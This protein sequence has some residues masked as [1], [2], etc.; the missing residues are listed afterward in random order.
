MDPTYK[1]IA[2]LFAVAQPEDVEIEETDTPREGRTAEE[3]DA[4][5]RQFL[6]DGNLEAALKHFRRAVEQR[7]PNDPTS[8]VNLAG[9]L[10]YGDQ[11]PQ[12]LRQYE[13]ALRLKADNVEPVVGVADL[14][15]RYGRFRDAIEKLQ[16]AVAKE[17]ENAYLFMKLAE[18]L[19][20]AGSKK[21]ALIEAQ[22]A[23]LIKPDESFYHYWI[24]DLMIEMGD[25]ENALGSLRAAIELSPGDDHLYLRAA[26]AFWREGRH[27][28]AIKSVRLASDLDPAKNL[29]HGL[30]GMM[31]EESGQLDEA[32]LESD[33]AK[34]MDRFDH[35][36][37]GRLLDEMGIEL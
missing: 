12:A 30:L 37:L 11:A 8:M 1:T 18:T 15:K 5:G 26:V 23:V 20:E 9:A 24:G 34:K 36:L 35:D 4:L 31:L 14:Y 13:R 33:R 10:E 25:Y 7:D 3:S 6:G 21:Q 16:L 28:E 2:D 22:N 17:P 29:Y 19:R 32:K 27:V